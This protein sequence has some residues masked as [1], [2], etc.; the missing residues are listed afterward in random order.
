LK[1]ALIGAS[2]TP[3]WRGGEAEDVNY[4]IREFRRAKISYSLSNASLV[5]NKV[6]S[7]F[8]KVIS[9]SLNYKYYKNRLKSLCPDIVLGLTDWDFSYIFAARDLGIPLVLAAK[10]HWLL[11][12]KW[13]MFDLTETECQGPYLARCSICTIKTG[14][15]LWKLWTANSLFFTFKMKEVRETLQRIIVASNFMKSILVRNGYDE[16]SITVVENGV[17]LDFWRFH[18]LRNI[19]EKIVLYYSAPTKAKGAH[20]FVELAK[21][22]AKRKDIKFVITGY[23]YQK[24]G[25]PNLKSVGWLGREE[26]FKVLA[27]SYL[28]V[29]PS[30]WSEPFG[31]VVSQAM[32]VGRPVIAYASGGIVEQVIDGE[33]GF[34]VRRGDLDGLEERVLQLVDNLELAKEMGE[35]SRKNAEKKYDYKIMARKYIEILLE[36]L[37]RR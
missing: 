18:P 7:G 14:G 34:L 11:C 17:D 29:V 20:H 24:L 35:N 37:K 12:P 10:I 26:V 25:L 33:T 21:R 30:I 9:G 22:S 19:E 2:T 16:R 13:D 28:V 31:L 1:V 4:F 3:N 27:G 23:G 15:E 5:K 8:S 36:T 32:A 6:K